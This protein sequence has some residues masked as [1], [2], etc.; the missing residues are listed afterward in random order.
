MY[1]VARVSNPMKTNPERYMP[2]TTSQS[3]TGEEYKR[4]KVPV[5]RSS[6]RSR[7]EM[8]TEATIVVPLDVDAAPRAVAFDPDVRVLG[9]F[10]TR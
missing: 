8:N 6:A 4:A 10:Q 2:S 3:R 7:M 5:W 1:R 9:T